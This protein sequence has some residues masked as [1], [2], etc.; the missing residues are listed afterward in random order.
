MPIGKESKLDVLNALYLLNH[1]CPR[2]NRLENLP[3][4]QC[5]SIEQARMRRDAAKRAILVYANSTRSPVK[6][7][8]RYI[9]R[10]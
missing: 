8:V 6:I 1:R 5:I 3:V 4:N 9:I 2:Q 7:A 10:P